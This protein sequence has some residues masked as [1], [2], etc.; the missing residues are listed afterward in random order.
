V[1]DNLTFNH[2]EVVT[3]TNEARRVERE[4]VEREL[5][6]RNERRRLN[7]E[8]KLRRREN[9]RLFGLQTTFYEVF[10]SGESIERDIFTVTDVDGS[11]SAGAKSVG[12]RGGLLGELMMLV[13]N[14]QT[15]EDFKLVRPDWDKFPLLM[16]NLF[17]TFVTEGMTVTIGL[18]PSF[19]TNVA[20][21]VEGFNFDSMDLDYIRNIESDSAYEKLVEYLKL[22]YMSAYWD[23]NCP[24]LAMRRKRLLKKVK[25]VAPKEEPLGN[26]DDDARQL[27]DHI[28]LPQ[29]SLQEEQEEVE[30]E[31]AHINGFIAKMIDIIV[32]EKYGRLLGHCRHQECQVYQGG[33]EAQG[34]GGR[35]Q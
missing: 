25:Y 26:E 14:C 27:D 3:R 6:E 13:G 22:H 17:Q 18:H 16:Q 20:P 1:N 32:D 23:E 24:A 9:K 5:Y 33:H 19:E 2:N 30:P 21:F 34:E 28:N 4:R 7:L 31:V 15:M 10:V 29:V 11:D 12:F 35:V 8:R